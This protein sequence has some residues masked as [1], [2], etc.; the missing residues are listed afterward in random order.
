MN[1]A[2]LAMRIHVGKMFHVGKM[3]GK[4][5]GWTSLTSRGS[6]W[7]PHHP[8]GPKRKGPPQ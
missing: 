6:L 3:W 2:W 8:R 7:T 5:G 4:G 1:V